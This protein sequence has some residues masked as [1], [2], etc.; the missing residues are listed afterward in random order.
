[1]NKVSGIRLLE[2]KYLE[3]FEKKIQA[4]LSSETASR[5]MGSY[6]VHYSEDSVILAFQNM[7]QVACFLE[8]ARTLGLA[9]SSLRI[10]KIVSCKPTSTYT[11]GQSE[12]NNWA[13][14]QIDKVAYTSQCHKT[15]YFTKDAYKTLEKDLAMAHITLNRYLT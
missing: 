15:L 13:R 11:E 6:E 10:I 5:L 4:N 14:G 7:Q 9:G 2:Q 3:E 1:M 8:T 12:E